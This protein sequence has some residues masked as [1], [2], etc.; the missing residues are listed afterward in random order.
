MQPRYVDLGEGQRV[1]YP[2]PT[3]ANASKIGRGNR[4]ADTKPEVALRSALHEIGLRFRKDHPVPT[5]QGKIRVDIAFPRVRLAI[6]V[7]GCFWHRCPVHG[8]L[9]KSNQ[10]YWLPKLETNARRDERNNA[11]LRESGWQ[12]LRFWEHESVEESATI[13]WH[14]YSSL[15]ASS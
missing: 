5:A 2:D 4:R 10:Q 9:P 14:T 13:V 6:F 1:A 8:S 7:D 15:R 12:V 3:S 11:Q